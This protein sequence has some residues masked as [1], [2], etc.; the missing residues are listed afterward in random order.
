MKCPRCETASLKAEQVRGLSVDSCPECQGVWVRRGDLERLVGRQEDEEDSREVGGEDDGRFRG[1][2]D[3][4]ESGA[5][6]GPGQPKGKRKGGWFQNI[7]DM[8]GGD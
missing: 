5:R 7:G 1:H 4:D 8:L 2:D 6:G 3:D